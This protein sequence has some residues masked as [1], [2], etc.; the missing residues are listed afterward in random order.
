LDPPRGINFSGYAVVHTGSSTENRTHKHGK[1]N[2]LIFSHVVYVYN[3]YIIT[4]NLKVGVGN[5]LLQLA[6]MLDF[7]GT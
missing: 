3:M 7:E 1:L 6:D 4:G 5:D 2:R